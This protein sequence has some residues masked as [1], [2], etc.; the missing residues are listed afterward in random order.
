MLGDTRGSSMLEQQTLDELYM[1][2]N[3][4]AED[5]KL[6][7]ALDRLFKN[8]DFNL[9]IVKGYLTELAL[10]LVKDKGASTCTDLQEINVDRGIRSIGK[11][12]HY[13][14][15]IRMNAEIAIK[16]KEDAYTAINEL[17]KGDE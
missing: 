2:A 16:T 3:K 6:N 15:S 1:L 17:T 8:S 14:D 5:I 4:S 12:Q 7:E 13:L 9:V 11:L 10:K